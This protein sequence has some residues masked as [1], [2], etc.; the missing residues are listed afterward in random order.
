MMTGTPI[1]AM[2][3]A[4]GRGED[5]ARES[6]SAAIAVMA[7][8]RSDAG[9]ITRCDEV[10]NIPRAMCGATIPAKPIGPQNA[11]TAAV[12][13]Q[14]LSIDVNLIL[15]TGAPAIVANSSPKR[16]ISSP[17]ELRVAR[18]YPRS[19]T[20]ARIAISLQPLFEKLPADQL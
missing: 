2:E 6:R 18:I 14:Q 8:V 4:I 12:V 11:V 19:R 16:I 1:I 9:R 10:L 20:V 3:L 17:F 15:W 7:P 13:R 5:V